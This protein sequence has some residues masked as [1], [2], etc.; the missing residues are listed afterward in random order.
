M[1]SPAGCPRSPQRMKSST[2]RTPAPADRWSLNTADTTDTAPDRRPAAPTSQSRSS[3]FAAT[4]EELR[5]AQLHNAEYS[6]R[7]NSEGGGESLVRLQE[8]PPG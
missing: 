7:L 2:R 8:D 5:R 3:P 6:T 1:A 4:S